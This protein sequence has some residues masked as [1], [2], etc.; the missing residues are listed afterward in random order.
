MT[1]R[2]TS[3][4]FDHCSKSHAFT[5]AMHGPFYTGVLLRF[6][7]SV[8]LNGPCKLLLAIQIA[9]ESPVCFT[10]DLK[11]SSAR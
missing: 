10:S 3:H 2:F 1:E 11:I 6:L 5:I 9:T 4:M 8:D 7:F